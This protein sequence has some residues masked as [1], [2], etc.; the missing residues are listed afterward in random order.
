MCNQA[1]RAHTGGAEFFRS[2]SLFIQGEGEG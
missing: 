1:K 2:L